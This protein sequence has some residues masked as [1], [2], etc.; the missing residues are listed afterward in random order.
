MNNFNLWLRKKIYFGLVKFL[1]K[2]IYLGLFL[3]CRH[4]F[5]TSVV[6]E[7]VG[8]HFVLNSVLPVMSSDVFSTALVTIIIISKATQEWPVLLCF[9]FE[10]ESFER[11]VLP[12]LCLGVGILFQ[13]N[14]RTSEIFAQLLYLI[15][16]LI[17]N[18]C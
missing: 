5:I 4:S 6:M 2:C 18:L 7:G 14:Q 8:L 12:V 16:N 11:S 17:V 3:K 13:N 10:K 9:G 15:A 1:R